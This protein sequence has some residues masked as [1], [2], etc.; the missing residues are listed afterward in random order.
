[1]AA[2]ISSHVQITVIIGQMKYRLLAH[3]GLK[4]GDQAPES[5]VLTITWLPKGF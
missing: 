4:P 1:M 5:N 2:N 3:W